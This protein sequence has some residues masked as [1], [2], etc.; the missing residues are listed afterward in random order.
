MLAVFDVGPS[1]TW[2][3]EDQDRKNKAGIFCTMQSHF[4]AV[5]VTKETLYLKKN[6]IISE[7]I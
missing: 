6:P 4:K 3:S 2:R 5:Q 7:N 1:L